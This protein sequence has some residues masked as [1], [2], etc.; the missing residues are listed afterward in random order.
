MAALAFQNV[1]ELFPRVLLKPFS[2]SEPACPAVLTR[3]AQAPSARKLYEAQ[4][5]LEGAGGWG[6]GLGSPAPLPGFRQ[7]RAVTTLQRPPWDQTEAPSAGP[8]QNRPSVLLPSPLLPPSFPGSFW[9][10]FPGKSLAHESSLGAC[11]CGTDRG[12]SFTA[13]A[14]ARGGVLPGGCLTGSAASARP[15]QPSCHGL[16][17]HPA[18]QSARGLCP[19]GARVSGPSV[20]AAARPAPRRSAEP[21]S[22]RE[23][24]PG[25]S[26]AARGPL[27]VQRA[28]RCSSAPT[29]SR[30]RGG[31]GDGSAQNPGGRNALPPQGTG[32]LATATFSGPVLSRTFLSAASRASGCPGHR[33]LCPQA[34]ERP[35]GPRSW[36]GRFVRPT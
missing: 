19:P 31:R 26:A 36:G 30:V 12:H 25:W 34:E 5:S 3:R 20:R 7:R 16:P 33:R 18:V 14:P 27:S 35:R 22:C 29:P 6:A 32:S 21:S 23:G 17:R 9:E 10:H 28:G 11:F 4:I 13:F 15:T 24:E 2:S 8:G 1:P